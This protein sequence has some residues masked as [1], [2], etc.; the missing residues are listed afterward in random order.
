[1]F[2][3]HLIHTELV[4]GQ[5]R[6][7]VRG[8]VTFPPWMMHEAREAWMVNARDPGGDQNVTRS[9][10][11]IA[12]IASFIGE[13]GIRHE[14]EHLTADGYFSVDVYLPDADVALEVA[15]PSH[16]NHVSAGGEGGAPGEASRAATKTTHTELRDR[17]IA[18]RHRVRGGH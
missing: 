12:E 18:K 5:V 10:K 17:F 8:E 6:N 2:Q 4:S 3:A 14:V 1:M 15:G 11:E 13:L 9:H 16:F 7:A